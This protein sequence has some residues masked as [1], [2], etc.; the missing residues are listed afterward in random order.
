MHREIDPGRRGS[1]AVVNAVCSTA[2]RTPGQ[3]GPGGPAGRKRFDFYFWCPFGRYNILL[4]MLLG[5]V[6][7]PHHLTFGLHAR[8]R[9]RDGDRGRE[10]T[11]RWRLRTSIPEVCSQIGKNVQTTVCPRRCESTK[12][13]WPAFSLPA[14]VSSIQ[15]VSST[16]AGEGRA[17][18][19]PW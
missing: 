1:R 2:I 14:I 12:R 17:A 4:R 7:G 13:V 10:S 11:T 18:L 6:F 19:T 9:G 5:A 8:G 15:A 3:P 16:R